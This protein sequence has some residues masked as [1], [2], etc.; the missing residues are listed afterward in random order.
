MT[1][2][3]RT[4]LYPA[5]LFLEKRAKSGKLTA[6]DENRPM[7]LLRAV[8]EEYAVFMYELVILAC[9]VTSYVYC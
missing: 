5:R 4:W 3:A 2:R 8:N 1:G 9:P 6:M 7:M